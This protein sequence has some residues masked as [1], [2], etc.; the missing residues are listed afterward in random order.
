MTRG[1]S[2]LARKG[3]RIRPA[4]HGDAH[5]DKS[6]RAAG[7]FMMMLHYVTNEFCRGTAPAAA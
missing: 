7:G 1:T 2:A 6:Y 4:V 3:E 5:V